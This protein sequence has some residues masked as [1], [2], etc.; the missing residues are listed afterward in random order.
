MYEWDRGCQGLR[1]GG[2]GIQNIRVSFWDDEHVLE[3][4]SD[5]SWTTLWIY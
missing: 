2:E 4:A 3:L 1:V 5:N